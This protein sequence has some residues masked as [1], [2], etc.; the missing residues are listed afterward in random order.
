MD[1]KA[2]GTYEIADICHVT[3]ST[4]GNWIGKGLLP[5]FSTGGGHRRVWK[6]DLL[7]FLKKHN[8][9]VSGGL[10]ANGKMNILIVDDEDDVRRMVRRTLQKF[11][12]DAGIHEAADG[13]EA[14]KKVAQIVP[15]LVILDL[16]LPGVDGFKVC[17]A[18]RADANLKK[19]KVLT[20]S[21]NNADE[22]K[23]QAMLAREDH[24]LGET[25]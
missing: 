7:S 23:K 1:K 14:G 18:I 19:V 6:D 8:I 3:P 24:F 9:P 16:K 17:K 12:P 11:Y 5:T 4:V 10:V 25:F 15:A 2:Y 20:I 22:Y 13:F 21:G